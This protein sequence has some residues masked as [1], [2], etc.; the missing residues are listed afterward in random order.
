MGEE[1]VID[2][3]S[4]NSAIKLV[5]KKKTIELQD[6][7]NIKITKDENGNVIIIEINFSSLNKIKNTEAKADSVFNSSKI[8]FKFDKNNFADISIGGNC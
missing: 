5:S 6:G 1:Y 4:K 3:S 7:D 8:F 2:G